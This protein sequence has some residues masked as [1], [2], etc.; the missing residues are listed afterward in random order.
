[1][2]G[3]HKEKTYLLPCGDLFIGP[4]A[5]YIERVATNFMGD[6]SRLADNQRARYACTCGIVLDL[7]VTRCVLAVPPVS[8]QGCHHDPVLWGYS[9]DLDGLKELGSRHCK[10][11]VV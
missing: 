10:R 5:R 1:M 2:Q 8:G 4:D 9:A 7:E 6:I 3:N 11:C